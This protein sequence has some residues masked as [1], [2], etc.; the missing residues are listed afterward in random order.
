MSKLIAK[1]PRLSFAALMIFF[2]LLEILATPLLTFLADERLALTVPLGYLAQ[3]IAFI[4]PFLM[5]GA[6]AGKCLRA[7]FLYALDFFGIFA[8]VDFVGQIP[9]AYFAYDNALSTP[10]WLMLLIYF[11]LSLLHSAFFLLLLFLGYLLFTKGK[12]QAEE[13]FFGLRGS[14]A[15]ML[16]LAAAV[17]ALQELVLFVMDFFGHLRDKLFIFEAVD[18]LDAVLSL[19]FIALCTALAF[20]AGRFA[21][22]TLGAPKK[23]D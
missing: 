17:I 22:R 1:Y 21:S 3:A 8:L 9:L 6:V 7:P 14:D 12:A 13:R 18:L 4:P 15:R 2:A 20:T 16:A 19:L 5:I 10:L 11:G 23:A